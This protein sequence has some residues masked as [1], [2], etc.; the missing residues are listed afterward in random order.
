VC[1]I[2]RVPFTTESIP[3]LT[4]K[5]ALITGANSGLGLESARALA[6]KGAHVILAARSE[7][8]GKQARD[9]IAAEHP[10]ASLEIL[11]LDL[12]NLSSLR[13][14]AAVVKSRHKRLDI[15]L[16]NAGVM[17]TPY[18]LTEDGFEL[19]FGTNHLG[20]FA[21][22]GLLFELL[23][24]APR[25]RV[26]NVSSQVH[27]VGR[28]HFDDLAWQ[29][30]YSKWG[31]YNMSKLANLLFTYEL[32][33]RIADK[34]L[35]IVSVAAHPGYAATNLQQRGAE[36]AGAKLRAKLV[37]LLNPIGGQSA[38]MGA[39]PQLYAATAE[40]VVPCDYVGAGG[41]FGARGYPKKIRSAKHSYDREAMR[42]LWEK[43]EQLTSVRYEAL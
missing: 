33:Q 12:S 3:N 21:L 1:Q 41:L 34:H 6:G 17:A 32:A 13:C 18:K 28:M 10:L 39:L 16:N 14:A 42:T 7:E 19:Q 4:G 36:L 24:N 9:E 43:S 38:A 25:A 5:T 11:A 27:L 22:T 20:H 23:L 31:A 15:L 40:D 8:K 37:K 35:P 2:A 29:R 26:V 30:G